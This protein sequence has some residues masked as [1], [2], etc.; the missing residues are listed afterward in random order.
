MLKKG[1]SNAP[2]RLNGPAHALTWDKGDC[3]WRDSWWLFPAVVRLPHYR[4]MAQCFP[5]HH[6]P[7]KRQQRIE[8]VFHKK[9]TKVRVRPER[10]DDRWQEVQHHQE[11]QVLFPDSHRP[12]WPPFVHHW[13]RGW[14]RR[15]YSVAEVTGLTT[16]AIGAIGL[17]LRVTVER[18]GLLLEAASVGQLAT[19]R[20]YSTARLRRQKEA[21]VPAERGMLS[22]APFEWKQW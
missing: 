17:A 2:F 20:L 8:D 13:R 1:A 11:E 12:H 9:P 4:W 14:K 6:T 10:R 22:E 7:S 18:D 21:L 5:H 3:G 19:T 15:C 16:T